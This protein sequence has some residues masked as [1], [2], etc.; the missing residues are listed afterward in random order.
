MG[1]I[2]R[3][4]CFLFQLNDGKRSYGLHTWS[5]RRYAYATIYSCKTK[6]SAL[7]AHHS[8]ANRSDKVEY[9]RSVRGYCADS[10]QFKVLHRQCRP[11]YHHATHRNQEN[12]STSLHYNNATQCRV[13]QTTDPRAVHPIPHSLRVSQ[14]VTLANQSERNIQS[15]LVCGN[16]GNISYS[17]RASRIL[18]Q[19]HHK[20]SPASPSRMVQRCNLYQTPSTLS[21]QLCLLR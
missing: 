17:P 18:S 5:S 2:G 6:Y 15:S 16:T 7:I 11:A 4:R 19:H 20:R 1:I 10:A 13:T 21:H 9:S 12:S 14:K 8:D 3:D